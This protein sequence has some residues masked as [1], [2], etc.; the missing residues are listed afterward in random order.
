MQS[1]LDILN[2]CLEKKELNPF[3]NEHLVK[4]EAKKGG[5]SGRRGQ[6]ISSSLRRGAIGLGSRGR[7]TDGSISRLL[8][9]GKRKSPSTL[10]ARG[11]KTQT[12]ISL[13]IKS[14]HK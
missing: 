11:L 3:L 7:G 6:R 1:C 9:G 5:H 4:R 10:P 14:P 12:D 8:R 13:L 2:S